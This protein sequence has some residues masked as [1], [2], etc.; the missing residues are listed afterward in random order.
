MKSFKKILTENAFYQ[1]STAVRVFKILLVYFGLL[2]HLII[3]GTIYHLWEYS[4]QLLNLIREDSISFDNPDL[5]RDKIVALKSSSYQ[6][7][8]EPSS[9]D[10]E[11]KLLSHRNHVNNNSIHANN[12]INYS[13]YNYDSSPLTQSTPMTSPENIG[14]V[15]G[16]FD[17]FTESE[18][19]AQFN[20]KGVIELPFIGK[21]S[22]NINTASNMLKH[23]NPRRQTIHKMQH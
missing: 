11:L 2:L 9:E 20:T 15:N 1:A 3:G 12:T 19:V 23:V 7:N 22:D 21:S 17:N 5:Y 14:G 16:N 4:K 13:N 18:T 6:N 8:I 10:A